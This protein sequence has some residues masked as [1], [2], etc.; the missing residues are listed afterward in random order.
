MALLDE[1]NG[2][3]H[4]A[5]QARP[6][7]AA[8][9]HGAAAWARRAA[10]RPEPLYHQTVCDYAYLLHANMLHAQACTCICHMPYAQV[11]GLFAMADLDGGGELD[12]AELLLL[13]QRLRQKRAG[14]E[15]RVGDAWA[16]TLNKG[17]QRRQAQQKRQGQGS[18][19]ARLLGKAEEAAEAQMHRAQD[20]RNTASVWAAW[21]AAEEAAA[22]EA[23][24]RLTKKALLAQTTLTEEGADDEARE[25]R[26]ARARRED[27]RNFGD[28]RGSVYQA[29]CTDQDLL[30]ACCLLLAA[31]CLLLAACC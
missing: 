28:R 8:W 19:L 18:T 25:A 13:L 9:A 6:S 20:T 16:T 7:A 27:L 2:W 12:Q 24:S 26:E 31:C 5:I 29:R 17:A 23:D 4:S 21:H 3:I 10:A 22:R 1:Q 11:A 14:T 30:A 15:G